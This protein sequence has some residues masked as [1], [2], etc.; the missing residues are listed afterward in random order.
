MEIIE[1]REVRYAGFWLRL[2]AY[3]IDYIVLQ[4]VVGIMS[5]PFMVGMITGIIAASKE[6][7]EGPEVIA[8]VGVI[9]SFVFVIVIISLIVGW[10][11]YALLESSK[12]QGTLGKVAVGIKVTDTVGNKITFAR[13][14]GRYFGKII[15]SMTIYIGFIMAG[16]T[17]K[18]QALHDIMSDCLVIKK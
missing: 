13:A 14:T 1:P 6:A 2:A 12:Y 9:M 3:I 17:V 8:I 15:S 10:L 5:L 7:S 16:F 4:L 18:K 11:Y